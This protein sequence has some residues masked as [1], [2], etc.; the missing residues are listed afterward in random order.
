MIDLNSQLPPAC[1]H[2]FVVGGLCAS[3]TWI[4]MLTGLFIL[5][6][7][8][9]KSDRLKGRGQTKQ[10]DSFYFSY[11]PIFLPFTFILFSCIVYP[12]SMLYSSVCNLFALIGREAPF[13]H[14]LLIHNE[15]EKKFTIILAWITRFVLI[16]KLCTFSP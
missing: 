12:F 14:S 16:A 3:V 6:L 7:G 11:F 15:Y 8:P 1:C 5:L 9:P 2:L 4:A 10:Q 13:T